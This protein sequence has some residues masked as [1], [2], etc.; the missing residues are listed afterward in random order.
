MPPVPSLGRKFADRFANRR[1]Y[2][3]KPTPLARARG[4]LCVVAFLAAAGWVAAGYLL[5]KDNGTYRYTHG[6]VAQVHGQLDANC[7]ACHVPQTP[8]ALKED[9]LGIH[10]RWHTFSCESCHKA[11]DGNKPKDY[12]PHGVRV[13]FEGY[14]H[15]AEDCGACHRDHNGRGFSLVRL[16]DSDCTGCHADM[17]KY[18]NENIPRV[19]STEREFTRRITGFHT[20]HP[21]FKPLQ[22]KHERKLK[23]DHARHLMPWKPD[24]SKDSGGK[25]TSLFPRADDI[26]PAVRNRYP[27]ESGGTGMLD[28][29]SCHTPDRSGKYFEPV[30]FEK[31]CVACHS[32]KT[33]ELVTTLEPN[34]KLPGLELPHRLQPA[35]LNEW[36]RA[37]IT[38]G[39]ADKVEGVKALLDPAQDR[40]D[41]LTREKLK[42]FEAA[43]EDILKK[44]EA[45]LYLQSPSYS[46][47]FGGSAC[48]KCH[49]MEGDK[50]AKV[51]SPVVWLPEAKFSHVAHRPLDCKA[52]HPMKRA[53]GKPDKE[54]L[55]ADILGRDTCISC[56]NPTAGVRHGCTDCHR[57]HNGDK[58]IE[59]LGAWGRGK[60]ALT[61]D[62][63][64]DPKLIRNRPGF[65]NP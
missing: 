30:T 54:L 42:T 44:E 47:I 64:L 10:A 15:S 26:S 38:R 8:S 27:S 28:C 58:A 56:H 11:A 22:E 2:F 49:T 40:L 63:L 16:P 59:G 41:P 5:K 14:T 36:M 17:A 45:R 55:K 24:P 39:L 57:Y 19:S 50:I 29:A 48:G 9:V 6:P 18:L 43:V 46:P 13:T 1:A 25:P 65:V 4:L 61:V 37:A 53:D 60:G 52:C 35:A 21:D 7:A 31:N 62:E 34:R 3:Q 32:L 33:Q 23:F 12:A 20:D 51:N